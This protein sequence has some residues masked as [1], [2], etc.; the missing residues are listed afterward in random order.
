MSDKNKIPVPEGTDGQQPQ[1]PDDGHAP[2]SGTKTTKKTGSDSR[3]PE[4]VTI[5]VVR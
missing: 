1:W 5:P 2:K 4:T 3:D